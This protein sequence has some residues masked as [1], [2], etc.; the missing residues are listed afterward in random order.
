MTPSTAAAA[1]PPLGNLAP[2]MF[3]PD[4]IAKYHLE[5]ALAE[6]RSADKKTRQ[7]MMIEISARQLALNIV[8]YEEMSRDEQQVQGE[9]QHAVPQ[10]AP[11][12]MLEDQSQAA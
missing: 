6:V 7:L 3:S 12:G 9:S 5:R 4:S 1:V 8:Q 2:G 10:Q 11:S